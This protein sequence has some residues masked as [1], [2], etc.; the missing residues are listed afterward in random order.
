MNNQ[1]TIDCF[2]KV[3]NNIEIN[4]IPIKMRKYFY[5]KWTNQCI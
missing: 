4:G 3:I 5:I 2:F 1:S